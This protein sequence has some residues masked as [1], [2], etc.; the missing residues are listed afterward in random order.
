M[1]LIE[2]RRRD[3]LQD[4]AFRFEPPQQAPEDLTDLYLSELGLAPVPEQPAAN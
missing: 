4:S 3:D 1:E 2:I